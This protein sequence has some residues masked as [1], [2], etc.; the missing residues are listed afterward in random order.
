MKELDFDIMLLDII[1]CKGV[2]V[3]N[4]PYP[5]FETIVLLEMKFFLFKKIIHIPHL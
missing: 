5:S 3:S 4:I 1:V 2:N